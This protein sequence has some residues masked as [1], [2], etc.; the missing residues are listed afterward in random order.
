MFDRPTLLF[1]QV[2]WLPTE[3]RSLWLFE[4]ISN[5]PSQTPIRWGSNWPSFFIAYLMDDLDGIPPCIT[6]HH[7]RSCPPSLKMPKNT[8]FLLLYRTNIWARPSKFHKW[9]QRKLSNWLAIDLIEWSPHQDQFSNISIAPLVSNWLHS[10]MIVKPKDRI[11]CLYWEEWIL[12][13]IKN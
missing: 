5:H 2:E 1:V 11:L 9:G 8:P 6:T 7:W 13:S 10:N 4:L 12:N 3:P